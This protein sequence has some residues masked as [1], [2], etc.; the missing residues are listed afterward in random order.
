MGVYVDDMKAPFRGMLMCH[1]SA[2]STEE[3]LAMAD[4]IKVAR[5]WIQYPGTYRE[6]FDICLSKRALAVSY[7]AEEVT[8]QKLARRNLAKSA[9]KATLPLFDEAGR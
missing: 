9:T 1:M 4:K 5:K 8:Q 3:L 7:G 2:D 6:H